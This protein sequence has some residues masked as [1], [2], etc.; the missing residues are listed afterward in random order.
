VITSET[1]AVLQDILH[2]LAARYPCQVLLWPVPVQGDGAAAKI[3]AAIHGMNA[4]ATPP[5]VIIVA[6]GGGSLEDLMPFNEEDVVR[7]AAASAIPLISAVGH[8]TDTTLLDYAADMRA[9]TPTAAAELATP[10]RQEVLAQLHQYQA[11]LTQALAQQSQYASLRLQATTA[12]LGTA[13]RLLE[14]PSQKLDE[15]T[16]RLGIAVRRLAERRLA[17]VQHLGLKLISPAAQLQLATQKLTALAARAP[18]AMG[19]KINQHRTLLERY[20]ALLNSHSYQA[21]LAR[22]FVLVRRG[23][24]AAKGAPVTRAAQL[25]AAD[26]IDLVFADST[27]QATVD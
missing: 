8:E 16:Q 7:A 24:P 12:R 21:V 18:R 25:H 26:K 20:G 2:R 5:D 17:Q 11:R 13:P 6:R 3:A 15:C 9:P 14:A 4:L 1:G 19:V 22:G 10:V 23:A 27:V